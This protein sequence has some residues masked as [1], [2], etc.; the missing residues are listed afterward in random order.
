MSDT[1]SP[2]SP[3]ESGGSE[4]T[5]PPDIEANIK[6]RSTWR[7]LLFMLVIGAL[8]AL[9]RPVVF[10]VVTLQF[11]WVLFT[12]E[13]NEKLAELGHS[14]GLYTAELIDYLCYVTEER[15]FP[16]DKDWP[17]GG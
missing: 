8:Y 3:G 6:N 16:F 2:D 1:R 9:S 12:A 7:R 11:F 10:A 17:D 15:P 13:R 4:P 5:D 14:L